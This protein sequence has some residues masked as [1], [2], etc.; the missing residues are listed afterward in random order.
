MIDL[1]DALYLCF[2]FITILYFVVLGCYML[3][4][5]DNLLSMHGEQVAKRRM[6][7]SVGIYML[8]WALECIVY[9]PSILIYGYE[10]TMQ[11]YDICFF[12]T[13][14]LNTPAVYA[15]MHAIVQKRVNT[16]LWVA[17]SSIP[18]L[19]LMA[20]YLVFPPEMTGRLPIY[21]AAVLVVAYMSL[22]IVRYA[23]EYRN[24]IR[25]LRTEYSETSNRE[26]TW[27][28][29]CFI[30]FAFQSFL[31][32]F[33]QFNWSPVVE[34]LYMFFSV[35]NASYLCY[36]TCHQRPLDNDIVE[37]TV[38]SDEPEVQQN[39]DE[40]EKTFY[41]SVQYKLE[42]L[43]EAKF[44]YLEPDLTRESLCLRLSIGRTYLSLYLRSRGLT[45]YQYINSLRVDYAVRLMQENP[46]M[47]IREV[48]ELSG[49]RSQTTFRKVFQEMM[50]CLPSEIKKGKEFEEV[51]WTNNTRKK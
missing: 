1:N 15:V 11:G 42:T 6:T 47:S 39:E 35:V 21:I 23:S 26:I 40:D 4:Q 43:C 37:Q 7:A 41:S 38:V 18:F 24:Y 16:L 48:S 33:Y 12:V 31:Y 44:L 3:S 8:V 51:V 9:L 17:A 5:R 14:M 46:Q 19:L 2:Y 27:A 28:W 50:G 25:R 29:S 30:G 34:Y 36:C 49:F 22:L 45:F 13:L 20:W 32:I 10:E